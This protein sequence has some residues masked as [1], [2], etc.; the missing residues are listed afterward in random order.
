[1]KRLLAL[2]LLASSVSLAGPEQAA[3]RWLTE[4]PLE[5]IV[6]VR[7][8]DG[9]YVV[10]TLAARHSETYTLRVARGRNTELATIRYKDTTS[11]RLSAGDL[12]PRTKRIVKIVA[13]WGILGAVSA[14][15]GG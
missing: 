13:I 7:L 15:F 14:W 3:A 9:R 6:Q 5:T 10:G 11:A 12:S 2:V 8:I 4:T 1:M